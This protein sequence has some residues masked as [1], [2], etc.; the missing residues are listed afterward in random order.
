MHFCTPAL[1]FV[2][3]A[4]LN[5][6]QVVAFAFAIAALPVVE[7]SVDDDDYYYGQFLSR[8]IDFTRT[9]LLYAYCS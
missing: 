7:L 2:T 4:R 9:S 1:K 6:A 5:V 8:E 3:F